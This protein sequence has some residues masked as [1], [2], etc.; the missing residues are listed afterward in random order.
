MGHLPI[1]QSSSHTHHELF[2]Q[3]FIVSTD[4]V[5]RLNRHFLSLNRLSLI[6]S[7][8]LDHSYLNRYWRV[9]ALFITNVQTDIQTHSRKNEKHTQR[10]YG[11]INEY[12]PHPLVYHYK[13]HIIL[14]LLVVEWNWCDYGWNLCDNLYHLQITSKAI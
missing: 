14:T 6:A 2:I 13:K 10:H 9:H 12:L 3:L 11:K 1:F 8:G 5:Y 7:T 4:F